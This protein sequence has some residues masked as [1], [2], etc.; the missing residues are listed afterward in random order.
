M[1]VILNESSEKESCDTNDISLMKES[2][3]KIED[4]NNMAFS[5]LS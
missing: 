4:P 2:T 3:P 1:T 5:V